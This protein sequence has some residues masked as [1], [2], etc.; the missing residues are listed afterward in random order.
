MTMPHTTA[1]RTPGT[2]LDAVFEPR[3][4]LDTVFRRALRHSRR[5]RFLRVAV[6]MVAIIA[7]LAPLLF[8]A[9]RSIS[10]TVPLGDFGRLVLTGNKLTMEAPRLAGFTKENRAYEVTAKRAQQDI[11]HPYVV[12]LDE[13]QARIELT[14]GRIDMT[15]EHGQLDAKTELLTLS[16]GIFIRSSQGYEGHLT[17]AHV[18]VKAGTVVSPRPVDLKFLQGDLRADTMKLFNKDQMVRFDGNV[19]LNVK[20]PQSDGTPAADAGARP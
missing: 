14:E 5:V 4:D 11:T 10:L 17:E 16:R 1:P 3:G 8:S 7:I 15:A 9:I 13:I 2:Q 18:D 12:D 20:L 19:V 6:P